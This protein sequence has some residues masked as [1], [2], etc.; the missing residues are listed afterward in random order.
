M[1]KLPA[2]LGEQEVLTPPPSVLISGQS[3]GGG[4]GTLVWAWCSVDPQHEAF[5]AFCQTK[6]SV[7]SSVQDQNAAHE[8]NSHENVKLLKIKTNKTKGR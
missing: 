5:I 4:A 8:L 3:A 2:A 6:R 1:L 7:L